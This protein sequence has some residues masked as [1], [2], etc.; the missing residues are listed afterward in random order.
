LENPYKKCPVYETEH[1]FIRLVQ[2]ED[3]ENLVECYSDSKSQEIFNADNCTGDFHIHTTE[4]MKL[5]L[6]AWLDA[7][8]QE[9]FIRFAIIDKAI[10][11]AVGTI[12]MFGGDT[13]ILR[14]DIAS[15]YEEKPYLKEIID[16]CITNFYNVFSVKSIATKAIPKA[17]NRIEAL[18]GAGFCLGDFDEREHYYLRSL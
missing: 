2:L 15:P 12:E 11:K 7:Y 9:A 4:N 8:E 18:C 5:C 13:G 16:V 6:S 14:L 1:F 3:A 10:D 17:Q